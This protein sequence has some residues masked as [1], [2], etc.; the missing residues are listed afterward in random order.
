MP[1]Y[2]SSN[3]EEIIRVYKALARPVFGYAYL[4]WSTRLLKHLIDN[5]EPIQNRA[6]KI[7]KPF[8]VIFY[9]EQ[10]IVIDVIDNFA[11][12]NEQQPNKI[13]AVING[14]LHRL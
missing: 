11:E 8:S 4:V 5:I 7:I 13:L 2:V 6:M 12:I 9:F 3:G 1:I 14:L 10:L